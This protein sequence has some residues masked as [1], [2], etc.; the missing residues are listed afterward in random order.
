M[1]EAGGRL[2]Q[3]H[4]EYALARR[5]LR[6]RCR[7]IRL[8]GAESL[9]FKTIHCINHLLTKPSCTHWEL[10]ILN[11]IGNNMSKIILGLVSS[12]IALIAA[13]PSLANSISLR[14]PFEFLDNR[15]SNDAGVGTGVVVQFGENVVTPNG[16]ATPPTTAT[17]TSSGGVTVSLPNLDEGINANLFTRTVADS[18]SNRGSWTLNFTNGVDT[19]TAATPSLPTTLAALPFV[20]SVSVSGTGLTP[21]VNWTNT[22]SSLDAVAIRIRDN[23]ITASLTPGTFSASVI[24]L[25]YFA[26]TTNS[27]SVPTGLLTAGHEYSIE[28]DQLNTRTPF[29][30]DNSPTGIGKTFVS[31]FNQSR[32]FFD[33][34]ASGSSLAASAVFLPTVSLKPD[35]LPAYTF[36]IDGIAAGKPVFIDPALAI[37]Y[38]YKIGL[39]DPNFASVTLPTLTG[40]ASYTI[41]LPDGEMIT[42]LP[43]QDFDFTKVAGFSGGVSN[44]EVLGINPISGLNAF[45]PGAFVTE[46]TFVS[47]G[48]FTGEMDP[49]IASVP[50]P[51]TWAMM[52]LGFA[53]IGFIR[54]RRLRKSTMAP[55]AAD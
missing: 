32:A 10:R 24:L 20:T 9:D 21:T 8:Q 18:S 54:Y 50:E 31:T 5:T 34:S 11:G 55:A 6:W 16:T 46:L 40:T 42:V 27:F 17:A 51:S 4:N 36:H 12:T 33:Y 52:I 47:A 49:I 13:T 2:T 19:A 41:L 15:S 37:G 43:G 29:V 38:S 28:I 39:G 30:A 35:G 3:A 22:A 14:G 1:E 26:P 7:L 23:G 53:G 44:F 45:D 48:S 25:N